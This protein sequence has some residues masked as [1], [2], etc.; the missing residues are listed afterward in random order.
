[1]TK[2]I[3]LPLAIPFDTPVIDWENCKMLANGKEEL[4]KT[5]LNMFVVSLPESLSI[6]NRCFEE[7]QWKGLGDEL[8][9]L[10]G[11]CCYAGTPR[12]KQITRETENAV[13]KQNHTILAELLAMLNVEAMHV[14]SEYEHNA[15]YQI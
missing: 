10:L 11:G 8:H 9:K 12:L 15:T 5:I 3:K 13:K 6:I 2:D 1:M 14:L 7:Q 4:A